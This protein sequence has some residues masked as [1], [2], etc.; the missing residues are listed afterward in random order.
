MRSAFGTAVLLILLGVCGITGY[1]IVGPVMERMQLEAETPTT[2]PDPYFE[3]EHPVQTT[4]A[5]PAEPMSRRR[6]RR[7]PHRK[8]QQLSPPQQRSLPNTARAQRLPI[9]FPR[10]H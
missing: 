1:N 5:S 2:T 8:R 7:L 6:S 9:W 4:E 3:T 10:M